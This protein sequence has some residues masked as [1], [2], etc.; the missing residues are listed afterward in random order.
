MR[1]YSSGAVALLTG[2]TLACLVSVVIDKYFRDSL[3]L[4]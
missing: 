1:W 4:P 2:P 3:R